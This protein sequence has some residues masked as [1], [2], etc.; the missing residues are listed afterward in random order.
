MWCSLW[1]SDC[2]SD[3]SGTTIKINYGLLFVDYYHCDQTGR[4]TPLEKLRLCPWLL[5]IWK[6]LKWCR[7]ETQRGIR[8][9]P[10][11]WSSGISCRKVP[12]Q[13]WK[14]LKE[15]L[16]E[17]NPFWEIKASFSLCLFLTLCTSRLSS[18]FPSSYSTHSHT[19]KPTEKATYETQL[20]VGSGFGK[21]THPPYLPC[22]VCVMTSW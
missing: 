21:E 9:V 10:I 19:Q 11:L 3:L 17:F 22:G 12:E 7:R 16:M 8:L 2:L 6:A 20:C 18:L 4:C 5:K 1:K 15:H 13:I 14:P